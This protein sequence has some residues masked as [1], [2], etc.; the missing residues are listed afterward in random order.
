[1]LSRNSTVFFTGKTTLFINS[2]VHYF[3]WVT[4]TLIGL[5]QRVSGFSGMGIGNSGMVER[6]NSCPFCL[7]VCLLTIILLPAFF[8]QIVLFFCHDPEKGT[9]QDDNITVL[10]K[11]SSEAF[12]HVSSIAT[13][14]VHVG[15]SCIRVVNRH[16]R[17]QTMWKPGTDQSWN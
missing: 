7:L 5:V 4:A 1:M 6:W 15:N 9:I 13:L 11:S 14:L 12:R 3:Q 8:T 10:N 2:C 17:C 16:F